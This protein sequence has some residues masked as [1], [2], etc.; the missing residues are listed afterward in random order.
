MPIAG[1]T[2]NNKTTITPATATTVIVEEKKKKNTLKTIK[3]TTTTSEVDVD[4]CQ[5]HNTSTA[6]CSQQTIEQVNKEQKYL[7]NN[8]NNCVSTHCQ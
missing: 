4:L 1:A 3:T 6:E 8:C 5:N 7:C 2:N